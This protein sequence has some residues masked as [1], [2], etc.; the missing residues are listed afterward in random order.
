MY[1]TGPLKLGYWVIGF[2]IH[3]ITC[4]IF[5][6]AVPWFLLPPLP[7]RLVELFTEGHSSCTDSTPMAAWDTAVCRSQVLSH[8]YRVHWFGGRWLE[9]KLLVFSIISSSGPQQ[10]FFKLDTTPAQLLI[11]LYNP[12][13]VLPLLY[14]HVVW[15]VPCILHNET[16]HAQLVRWELSIFIRVSTPTGSCTLMPL[17]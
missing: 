6:K 8:L 4:L 9:V 17:M 3:T 14:Y 2:K 5:A 12:G 1:G 11:E 7:A 15:S 10:N 16:A 13:D